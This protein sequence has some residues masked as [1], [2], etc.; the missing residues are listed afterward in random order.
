MAHSDNYGDCIFGDMKWSFGKIENGT[1]KN[2]LAHESSINYNILS[3]ETPIPVRIGSFRR[4]QDYQENS[5]C[6]FCILSI[7]MA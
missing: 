5:L 4:K 3:S 7:V 6:V 1:E 2:P